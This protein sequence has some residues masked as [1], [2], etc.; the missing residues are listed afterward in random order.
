MPRP[1]ADG[2]LTSNPLLL[3]R[4][5]IGKRS[6]PPERHRQPAYRAE[7]G[8]QDLRDDAAGQRQFK[9]ALRIWHPG[10]GSG[11]H[12]PADS[13]IAGGSA[14]DGSASFKRGSK[15]R[16]HDP[17]LPGSNRLP[18]SDSWLCDGSS[19]R[20]WLCLSQAKLWILGSKPKV[21]DQKKI[22]SKQQQ[23]V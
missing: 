18:R 8:E 16:Q 11:S 2:R 5:R 10:G 4:P 9:G 13:R 21:M 19:E 6:L 14:G 12:R 20:L 15:G 7:L 3:C 17:G 22:P 23:Q 1:P